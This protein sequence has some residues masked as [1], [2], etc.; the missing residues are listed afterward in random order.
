MRIDKEFQTRITCAVAALV[1]IAAGTA[2]AQL[3]IPPSTQFDVVGYLEEATLDLN[4]AADAHCGGTIKVQGHTIVVP[5][6]TVVLLPANALL[7]QELFAQ[8][9][10]P[11]GFTAAGSA[12]T[13]L[14]A[15]DLPAP[16]NNYE[17]H[18]VGNR[19]IN[20]TQAGAPADAYIAGLV[21]ITSHG[22]NSGNGFINFIDYTLGELRVGGILNDPNCIQGG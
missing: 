1:L 3:P 16:L 14:A 13:G 22:L 9:P 4:C 8:A 19:V 10:A 17:V 11:Y 15:A 6:E 2:K 18:V 7:W 20:N 21:Y 12:M 5:K